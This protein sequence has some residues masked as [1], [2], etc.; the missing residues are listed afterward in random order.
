VDQSLPPPRTYGHLTLSSEVTTDLI[1]LFALGKRG[2]RAA[3]KKAELP[4]ADTAPDNAGSTAVTAANLKTAQQLDYEG[5]IKTLAADYARL[6]GEALTLEALTGPRIEWVITN[7]RDPHTGRPVRA[8]TRNSYR[9][10]L[11]SFAAWLFEARIIDGPIACAV[12]REQEDEDEEAEPLVF[13]PAELDA[14]FGAI[15]DNDTVASLRLL[16]SATLTLDVGLRNSEVCGLKL[17]DLLRAKQ[18]IRV[19]GKR[20]KERFLPVSP[21]T[22]RAIDAYLEVRDLSLG[23]LFLTDDGRAELRPRALNRQ[24]NRILTTLGLANHL[25]IDD[26]LDQPDLV[27]ESRNAAGLCW[28]ALRRT[29]ATFYVASGRSEDELEAMMGWSREYAHQVRGHYV[30]RRTVRQLQAVHPSS[31]LVNGLFGFR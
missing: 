30:A 19:G 14:V 28:Q 5:K 17:T 16:A 6:C 4:H 25:S 15:R 21:V 8:A 18:Q 13:T 23:H 29:F 9:T 2:G 3:R 20:G 10:Y 22:W 1:E 7:K 11:K 26:L 27:D 24:F 31:T 12:R